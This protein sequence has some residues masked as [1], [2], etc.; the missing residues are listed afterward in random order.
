MEKVDPAKN[1]SHS[2]CPAFI[3]HTSFDQSVNVTNSYLYAK[4]LRENEVP[5]EM[6]IFPF[7]RHGLG[8]AE[9]DSHVAQWGNLLL[10]WL[11]YMDNSA[12]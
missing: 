9:S 7:G 5:V 11:E 6:H 12:E 2:T 4:A 1:A 10:N 8:L 3:W